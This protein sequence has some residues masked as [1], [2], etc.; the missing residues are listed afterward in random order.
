MKPQDLTEIDNQ[1]ETGE[2]SSKTVCATGQEN[3]GENNHLGRTDNETQVKITRQQK[4]DR[5][6]ETGSKIQRKHWR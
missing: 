5:K 2:V 6:T 3:R 1:D 4:Q